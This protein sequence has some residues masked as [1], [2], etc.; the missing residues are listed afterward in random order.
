MQSQKEIEFNKYKERGSLHWREM[1]S[2]DIRVF[3]AYQQARYEWILKIAGNVEGKK[4]LDLGSGDGTVTYI[5]ANAGAI[6]TGVDNEAQGLKY[7]K[8]N[9]ESMDTHKTLKYSFIEASAYDLP[10]EPEEFDIVVHCE[11]IE[12]LQE[13]EKMLKEVQRVLKKGGTCILTTPYKLTEHPQDINHIKEYYPGELQQMLEKYLCN[14][15]TKE[16]H[17]L[18]WR[19]LYGYEF[20]LFGKRPVGRWLINILTLVCKWNPFMIEYKNPSKFDTFATICAWG[21]K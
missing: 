12:H 19:S 8:E 5:L 14:V 15:H 1:V 3:N 11:V 13:P 20:R 6:V 16:T 21:S 17:H 7:A 10:F 9:L 4:V 18:L 2:K